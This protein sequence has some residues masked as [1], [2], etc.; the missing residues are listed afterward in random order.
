M[1]SL[2][3]GDPHTIGEYRLIGRLGSGGMGRVYLARS[4]RGRTVAVKLIHERL[5]Q[6]PAFRARFRQEVTAARRVGGEWTAPV[7][8]ADTEAAV[9]WVAT[10]YIA[11]PA[12]QDIVEHDHGPLPETSLRV[13]ADGLG[14]ALQ[15][16][17]AAGLIHRDLKPSNVL[18]TL[19]G[20]RVIDFGIARALHGTGEESVT[21]TGVA[22]G[23]PA[24]MSPEQV[25]GAHLTAASDVFSLGS[26][27]VYAA[28]GR[29]PFGT[30]DGGVL[31][32]MFRIAQEE[33]DLA[34]VPQGLLP[35]IGRCLEK[36]P[37][38][39]PDPAEVVALARAPR[40][41][42]GGEPWLPGGVLARLGRHAVR[43][44]E[45]EDPEAGGAAGEDMEAAAVGEAV[46]GEAGP[47][48]AE[49]VVHGGRRGRRAKPSRA[50]RSSRVLAVVAA[51]VAT[52]LAG[53]GAL[54]L[55]G[56][57][58]GADTRSGANAASPDQ[59]LSGNTG[60][61]SSLPPGS[62]GSA[63]PGATPRAGTASPRGSASAGPGT[64]PSRSAGATA[65]G[66][67]PG[68]EPGD[69]G[70]VPEAFLGSWTAE[71]SATL[72][73]H[74]REL[75]IVQG[76]IGTP[77]ITVTGTGKSALGATYTCVWTASLT[78]TGEPGAPLRVGSAALT[79]ADPASACSVDPA[80]TLTL[81]DGTHLRRD[82]PD[83]S[84]DAL[85]F[86]KV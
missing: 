66:A 68:G 28:S 42:S 16:V 67:T 22:V 56:G 38:L 55:S 62:T 76:S 1:Q 43:L 53:G 25:R 13:L 51:V 59:A 78:D 73:T 26:V 46:S 77:V 50:R 45:V 15:A 7:L 35:L 23:S 63:R 30:P 79:E 36:D 9:P 39:R 48:P 17:H 41:G 18:L 11:G 71:Y 10:G 47:D 80:S 70:D 12:L 75:T 14:R 27:L 5:A 57:E 34:G 84:R 82:W 72:A 37:A 31:G 20:P 2:E 86:T 21:R 65:P 83:G 4:D 29:M 85:T 61:P 40:V 52:A 32:L 24:F 54:L 3:A 69:E 74:K 60:A 64:K 19:D 58:G 44:L 33:P 49:P 8:D 6:E 81:T